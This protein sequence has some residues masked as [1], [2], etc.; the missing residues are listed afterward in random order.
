LDSVYVCI[1]DGWSN[2]KNIGGVMIKTYLNNG[3]LK[4]HPT[5]KYES[6]E[7]YIRRTVGDYRIIKKV[8][9]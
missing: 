6:L 5:R 3:K 9:K 8:G 2:I 1:N 7:E 4:K